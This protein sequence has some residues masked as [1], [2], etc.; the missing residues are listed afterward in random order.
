MKNDF[1]N[2]SLI[3]TNWKYEEILDLFATPFLELVY[4]AKTIHRQFFPEAKIQLSTLLSIKTGSCPENCKYCPQSAHYKTGVEKQDLMD[5]ATIMEY[6]KKAKEQGVTRFC[7]GASWRDLPD[8]ELHKIT[9]IVKQV[10]GLGLETCVTLGMVT[11]P[12]AQTLKDAGL[13]Y[14]NHNIDTSKEFY[15]NIITTR[16]YEER[17]NTI[18]NI[19]D[20]G[21]NVCCGGIIGM[22]E[23]I[24]DR[25]KMLLELCNFD[26]HPESVPINMLMKVAGTP[27]GKNEDVDIFD[28]IKT[29]AIARILMPRSMVRLSAGR[30][31][32]SEEAQALCFMAGANS[33]FYGE[34]KLLTTPNPSKDSDIILMNKLQIKTYEQQS[35]DSHAAMA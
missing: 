3:K 32:M 22:G 6:A 5:V 18:H 34:E 31:N 17:I 4:Q 21:I 26:P 19:R 14:Y 15:D 8:R 11:K 23:S 9:D 35:K 25:A 29:I 24:E 2:E 1:A 28:F 13:D 7:M 33:I 20:S 27:L 12:Q 16:T 10:K 30:V